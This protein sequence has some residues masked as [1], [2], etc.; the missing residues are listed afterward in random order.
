MIQRHK[1]QCVLCN[2]PADYC[3]A[4]HDKRK[5][6]FCPN[7]TEYQITDTAEKKLETAPQ[8]WRMQYSA[9]AKAIGPDL[10]LLI[11]V[12]HVQKTEGIAYESLRGEPTRREELPPCR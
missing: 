4:D 8:D 10:V 5:H 12:P 3:L 1:Q 9:K 6:F 2:S 7:C 11:S